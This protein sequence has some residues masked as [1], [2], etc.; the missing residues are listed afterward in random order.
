MKYVLSSPRQTSQTSK[1]V[2]LSRFLQVAGS[3]T[4]I[5][6]L[7]KVHTRPTKERTKRR[8]N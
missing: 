3:K 5:E 7:K 8:L 6:E 1:E 2:T 4:Y